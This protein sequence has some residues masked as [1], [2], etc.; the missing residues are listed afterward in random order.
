MTELEVTA[1]GVKLVMKGAQ[2]VSLT[3]NK[4]EFLEQKNV[5]TCCA[6]LT[7]ILNSLQQNY[8]VYWYDQKLCF[9][10]PNDTTYRFRFYTE[11]IESIFYN[12]CCA[13]RGNTEITFNIN[14]L[15][16]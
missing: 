14:F 10:I 16:E 12:F 11:K 13:T 8:I 1:N 7:E 15:I 4:K 6:L 2:P 5:Y 9:S 3:V